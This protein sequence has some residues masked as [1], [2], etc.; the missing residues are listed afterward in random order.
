MA[1]AQSAC[2][3]AAVQNP[4]GVDAYR[5]Y[6]LTHQGE[7]ARG[8]RLF[9]DELRLACSRCHSIDGSASKAGPD[10][11]AVGD[12]FGRRDILDAILMPSATIA[13]GYGTVV[14]QT[15][16]GT[17]YQGVL[18]QSTATQIQIMG[19]DGKLVTVARPDLEEQRGSTISLMPEGLQAGVSLQEFTDLIEYLVNLKQPAS[20][21]VGARGTPENIPELA[22]PV[23]AVPFFTQELRLPRGKVQ[24]GLTAIY[25]VPGHTNLF[26]VLHQK[27]MIWRMEKTVTGE[28]KTV[29]SDLTGEVF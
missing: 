16:D 22:K 27:G 14:L 11:F 17:E 5:K 9:A 10:L 4:P 20:A 12:A 3:Q 6:A 28:E 23:V 25:Q 26:L 19:A 29:F 1:V 7:A 24:T 8:A 13:P 15:K 18:K 21:L 2:L